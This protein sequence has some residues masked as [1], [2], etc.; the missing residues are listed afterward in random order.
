MR[1][2]VNVTFFKCQCGK[3]HT[4]GS[5]TTSTRCICGAYLLNILYTLFPYVASLHFMGLPSNQDV[6]AA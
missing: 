2:T 3:I 6:Y 1:K 4:A 5:V